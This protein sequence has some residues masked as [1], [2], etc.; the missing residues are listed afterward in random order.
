MQRLVFHFWQYAHRENP[1]DLVVCPANA[2]PAFRATFMS[3]T[4]ADGLRAGH[5]KAIPKARHGPHAT[6]TVRTRMDELQETIAELGLRPYVEQIDERGY[7]VVPP[8]VTGVTTA[9]VDELVRLLLDKSE[10]YI[11]CGFTVEGGPECE[12]DYGDFRG[13]LELRSGAT[14]SQFQLMQ[15]CT[16]HRAFRDL[17]VN[18]VGTALIRYM[19][20]S[21]GHPLVGAE[22]W[23]A[24]FSS[25]NSFIKWAGDG[26]G[27]SL[28]L[29][30]DQGGIPLPWGE[31]ALNANCNW[32]LTDYTREDG[33]FAC[34]PGSHLRKGHPDENAA[35]EAVPVECPRGSL[36][37]FHGALWHGAY[38]K[39]T[40]GLRVTIANYYRHMSILPQDDIP[41]HFP[42][43][44][45]DDCADPATFR[46]L[47]GFGSPYQS[48]V[49]PLP[50]AVHA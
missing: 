11:G 5:Y 32:C 3:Q 36:I 35:D 10:E 17:A 44:L 38:P 2:S 50:K 21:F 6:M 49:Y 15:L 31:K 45:A 26:Y 27:D 1:A 39:K 25:H 29:H 34:V 9:H 16:Y 18:P 28:G 20:G 22:A 30:V 33:A 43:E 47:A 12:L 37:A 42:Q 14:P 8:E 40:P 23:A 4:L 48:Q 19:I 7:A 24:R 46:E 13:V 41:N